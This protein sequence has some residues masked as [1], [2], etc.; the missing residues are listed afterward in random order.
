M[1]FSSRQKS[2]EAKC[3]TFHIFPSLSFFVPIFHG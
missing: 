2:C 3:L 1:L